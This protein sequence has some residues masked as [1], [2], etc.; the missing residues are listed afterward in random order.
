MVT[1]SCLECLDSLDM[2]IMIH[3]YIV[4]IHH[5]FHIL[6]TEGYGNDIEIRGGPD[7][8]ALEVPY[9][10]RGS[11]KTFPEVASNTTLDINKSLDVDAVADFFE[12][13]F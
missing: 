7:H 3:Y 5:R 9:V 1:Y 11:R 6:I 10:G 2:D 4:G 8:R 12:V 13:F